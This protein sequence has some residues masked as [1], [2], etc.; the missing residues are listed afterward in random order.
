[1]KSGGY[2]REERG[3]FYMIN[4]ELRV[5]VVVVVVVVMVFIVNDI[6]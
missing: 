3:I 1:V 5:K 6:P 4:V 2:F